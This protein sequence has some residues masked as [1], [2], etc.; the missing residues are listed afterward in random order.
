MREC[1]QSLVK[2][3]KFYAIIAPYRL[4]ADYGCIIAGFFHSSFEACHNTTKELGEIMQLLH[5]KEKLLEIISDYD[6]IENE[7]KVQVDSL[8]SL[9]LENEKLKEELSNTA[10]VEN[11][12]DSQ[13]FKDLTE[14]NQMLEATTLRVTQENEVL[15]AELEKIKSG[16]V[17]ANESEDIQELKSRLETARNIFKNQKSKIESL[18]LDIKRAKEYSEIK[19]KEAEQLQVKIKELEFKSS[20]NINGLPF[21]LN[22]FLDKCNNFLNPRQ[23]EKVGEI[24][25]AFSKDLVECYK[26]DSKQQKQKTSIST[27]GNFQ[28]SILKQEEL[29]F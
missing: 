8:A 20:N 4:C 24:L 10:N 15:R 16:K 26:S 13:E 27:A 5:L 3:F 12:K 21:S 18:E 22:E 6:K 17:V 28:E 2:I 23:R 29:P 9:Q 19:E 11:L 7:F 14:S 25:K 1:L